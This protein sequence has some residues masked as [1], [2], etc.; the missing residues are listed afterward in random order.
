MTCHPRRGGASS[1]ATMAAVTR[2]AAWTA[3]GWWAPAVG[4]AYL[5]IV[6]GAYRLQDADSSLYESI[7]S[8]LAQRPFAEWLAPRWIEDRPK[9]GLFVEHLAC[10]F[11][12]GALFEKAGLPRGAL[13]FNLLSVA[14]LCALSSRFAAR[15]WSD[16]R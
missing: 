1:A 11:W 7:A 4:I 14:A 16:E 13:L 12:P 15:F 6:V 5:A 10:Y 9:T 3:W 2:P 8:Q